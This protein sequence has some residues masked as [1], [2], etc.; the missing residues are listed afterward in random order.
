MAEAKGR[1]ISKGEWY[2]A[3]N[4]DDDYHEMDYENGDDYEMILNENV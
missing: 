3:D 2:R 1:K 4:D